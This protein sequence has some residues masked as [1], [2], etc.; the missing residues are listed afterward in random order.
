MVHL[1]T[2]SQREEWN[3]CLRGDGSTANLEFPPEIK[4]VYTDIRDKHC[5]LPIYYKLTFK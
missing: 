2:D 4:E 1:V 3:N 5:V